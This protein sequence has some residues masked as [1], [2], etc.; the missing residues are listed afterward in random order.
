MWTAIAAT[1]VTSSMFLTAL[2]PNLLAVELVRKTVQ[3]D[4]GW[5]DW[6]LSFLPVGAILLL[7]TPWLAYVI[8]PP[9]VRTSP[10]V[11]SW[12]REELRKLGPLT[13]REGVLVALVVAA[14]ALWIF[15]TDIMDPAT[16]AIL[17]V[18]LLVVTRTITW[19][20][21]LAN[22]PAWNTLVWFGTLVPLAAGLVQ[23]GV[24]KWIAGLLGAQLAGVSVVPAMLALVLAFFFLHYL[25]ASVTAHT[26][27]LLPVMLTVGAAI[28]G[29]PMQ[30]LSLL[31]CLTLGIM[32]IISPFATGPSPIYAGSGYLPSTDYWRLG[33]IFG[34][35]FLFVFLAIGVP[36]VLLTH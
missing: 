14:L 16:A 11:Q 18:A 17:V 2:A 9:E 8:Y 1:C 32:G 3:V 15:G 22:K 6:F 19:D 20:D 35:I 25:F 36:V 4:I 26:T 28:Q 7:A 21:I 29:M 13:R 23:V 31:L 27:A 10:E 5:M 12:A 33:G 24:V 30:T 34:L